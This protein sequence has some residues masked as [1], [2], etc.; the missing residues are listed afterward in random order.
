[1]MKSQVFRSRNLNTSN[2][3][4]PVMVYR[5]LLGP[6][7][8]LETQ[9]RSVTVVRLDL[10]GFGLELFDALG[11]DHSGVPDHAVNIEGPNNPEQLKQE[12]KAKS[13]AA[14][15]IRI[16]GGGEDGG[17]SLY[18]DDHAGNLI[19]LSKSAR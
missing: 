9:A 10:G 12:I 3:A 16:Y 14:N 7:V 8:R 15:H 19:E 6:E 13:I 2:L 18:V 4:E 1:M 11:R 5:D 17:H